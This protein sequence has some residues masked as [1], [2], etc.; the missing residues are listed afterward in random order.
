M[1]RKNQRL[2]KRTRQTEGRRHTNGCSEV[3]STVTLVPTHRLGDSPRTRLTPSLLLAVSPLH[4][5]LSFCI[6]YV[7]G[8]NFPAGY[9]EQRKSSK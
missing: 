9:Q 8:E 2:Q 6:R 1:I 5:V 3:L 7:P 4:A